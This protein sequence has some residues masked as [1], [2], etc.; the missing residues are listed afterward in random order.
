MT[1]AFSYFCLIK[2][3]SMKRLPIIA[4]FLVFLSTSVVWSQSGKDVFLYIDNQPVDSEEFVRL[5]QKNL[6]IIK[7]EEQRDL[8][9]YLELYINYKLKLAEAKKQGL[10]KDSEYLEEIEAYKKEQTLRYLNDSELS[11]TILEELYNRSKKEIHAS[12]ILINL[13]PYSYGKDTIK[14]Y[15]KIEG[16][17]ERALAGEDFNQLA[18]KYSEEPGVEN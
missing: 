3:N 6:E 17:R 4:L 10:D 7:D 15:E 16:L 11:E 2:I 14:A 18:E 12:H 5:Y 9:N 13:P 8:D 1:T